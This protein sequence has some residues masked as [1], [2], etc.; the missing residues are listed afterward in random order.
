MTAKQPPATGAARAARVEQLYGPGASN[1][2]ACHAWAAA[3]R[4]ITQADGSVY[5]HAPTEGEPPE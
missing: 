2:P 1:D 3:E 4:H 5:Q